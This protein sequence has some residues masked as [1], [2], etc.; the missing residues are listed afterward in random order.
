LS[1]TIRSG[2]AA[3]AINNPVAAYCLLARSQVVQ[4]RLHQAEILLHKAARLMHEAAGH[5]RGA[6]GLVEIETA[7]LLCEWNDVDAALV[8]VKGGLEDLP[9]WGKADDSCLA[10]VT[11]A[12]IEFARGNP[13]EAAGAIAEGAR[14]VQTCGVFSEAR[15][16]VE[17][18]QVRLWLAQGDWPAVDRWTAA[19][20]QRLRPREPIRYEDELARITQARVAL[21]R[22][23]PDEAVRL[24]SRLQDA[25][26]GDGRRGRLIQIFLLKPLARQAA[27]D[28]R[29]ALADLTTGLALAEPEGYV[30]VFLDEGPP[31]QRL[32]AK[33][34]SHVDAGSL[35]GYASRL[36][37]QFNAAPHGVMAAPEIGSLAADRAASSGQALIEPLSQRELEVLQL[38]ALGRTNQEI[39]QQLIVAPG[40]VK[41]HTANIYRKLDVANR[42]EAVAR[43][44]QLGILP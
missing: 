1:E 35:R 32:L 16:A 14:L 39:A 22:N 21:A 17:A 30:R 12:R 27:G 8:R 26:Q 19:L 18:A 40:T 31:M 28:T 33:A 13:A 5:Y 25:A 9:W 24:L 42:T 44:R 41:A 10:F 6:A 15:S 38:I 11:L 29:Q 23:Q 4:G 20:D 2:S 36:L 7:A 43:A 34:L 3:R 37:S